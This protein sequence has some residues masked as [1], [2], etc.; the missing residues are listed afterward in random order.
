MYGYG[1]RYNSGLVLG[2]G[3]GAPFANTYSLSFDGIDDYV[4]LPSSVDLGINNTICAWVKRSDITNLD[5]ITGESSFSGQQNIYIS[6]SQRVYM[7]IGSFTTFWYN[8]RGFGILNQVDTWFHLAIVRSG[9]DATLYLNG[10][11]TFVKSGWGTSITTKFDRIGAQS[12]TG[13]SPMFGNLDEIVAFD[14]VLTP[15]EITSISAAPTDLSSLSPLGWWR[16]E[17]GMGTTA[18]DSGSGGNNGT[19]INGV[20]YST[21]VP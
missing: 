8:V 7:K 13:N 1:Y 10:S 17:E 2:A 6:G 16:F 5:S 14:R 19:L 4:D 15:T 21:N 3:G 11:P 12:V 18:I 20:A 9:N